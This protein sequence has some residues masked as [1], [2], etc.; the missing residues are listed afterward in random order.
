MDSFY[1]AKVTGKGQIQ[2]P[3]GV[4][5]ALG[6]KTGDEIVFR[7][8]ESGAVYVTGRRHRTI[9][10]LAGCLKPEIPFSGLEAEKQAGPKAAIEREIR[11]LRE[12]GYEV[13]D[14]TLRRR[15]K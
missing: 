4:R 15:E 13:V 10:E 11:V 12:L 2:V 9:S 5:E 1:R 14:G 3:S 6:V 7:V 8:T